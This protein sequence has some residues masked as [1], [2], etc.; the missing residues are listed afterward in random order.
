MKN[1]LFCTLS[2]I[3]VVTCS[4]SA[5]AERK[6]VSNLNKEEK[7]YIQRGWSYVPQACAMEIISEIE[8]YDTGSYWYIIFDEN[9]SSIYFERPDTGHREI[10]DLRGRTEIS[11]E[12]KKNFLSID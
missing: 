2:M 9:D 5:I 1:I 4:T 3:L 8:Y 6:K 12:G 7:V 10:C 11:P